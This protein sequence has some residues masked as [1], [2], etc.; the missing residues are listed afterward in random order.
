MNANPTALVFLSTDSRLVETEIARWFPGKV[1][2]SGELPRMHT[3]VK[4]TEAGLMRAYLDVQLLANCD[5]LFLTKKSGVS[6][7]SKLMS[8]KTPNITFF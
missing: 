4:T 5:V 8:V 1:K 6:R 2:T 7:L 3:G